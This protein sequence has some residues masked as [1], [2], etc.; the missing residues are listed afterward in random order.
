MNELSHV[1]EAGAVRMVDVGAQAD[2]APPR[3]RTGDRADGARDRS[4]G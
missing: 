4:A 3:R 1:D 2:A